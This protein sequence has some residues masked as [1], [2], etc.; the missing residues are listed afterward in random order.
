MRSAAWRRHAR[1]SPGASSG[2][3]EASPGSGSRS[4]PIRAR[5]PLADIRGAKPLGGGAALVDPATG[6]T[7]P[8]GAHFCESRLASFLGAPTVLIDVSGGPAGAAAGIAEA[9]SDLGC[10]LVL[11]IDIGGD[12]IA[13]GDEPGLASPLCDAV[14]I[15]AAA[16]A[17]GPDLPCV[18]GVLGAGCDG[19]LRPAEVLARVAALAGAGAWIATI[20]VTPG[21]SDEIEAA[22]RRGGDG[23][24]PAGRP[25]RARHRSARSRSAAGA[26]RSRPGRWARSASCS[27]W[28]RRWPSCRWPAPSPATDVDRGRARGVRRGSASRPSSDYEHAARRR[29]I[30]ARGGFRRPELP[31]TPDVGRDRIAQLHRPP[32]GRRRG[33]RS[34]HARRARGSAPAARG[35]LR[36]RSRRHHGR[37]PPHTGLAGGG[38]SVPAGRARGAAA[39][40]DAGTSRAGRWRASC[41]SCTTTTSTGAPPAR[42]RSQRCAEPPSGSTRRS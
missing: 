37:R 10:D 19:E 35:S 28:R 7:T 16:A 36:P 32:R 41:T 24:E 14:M 5:G 30:G 4:T 33:L 8:E 26:G 6:A 34:A 9:A 29:R 23:G 22:A 21:R 39:A 13:A 11:L 15:A 17:C 25:L 20:G 18:L 27:T 31:L 1:S 42:T 12:A 2:S 38:P 3:S 40:P